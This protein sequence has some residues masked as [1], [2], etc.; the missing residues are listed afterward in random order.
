MS[1]GRLGGRRAHV[2]RSSGFALLSRLIAFYFATFVSLAE[3]Y[4]CFLSAFSIRLPSGPSLSQLPEVSESLTFSL[5]SFSEP[6]RLAISLCLLLASNSV[7]TLS[8]LTASAP[9]GLICLTPV[10]LPTNTI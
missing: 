6:H 5:L 7:L 8:S 3:Y 4:F 9:I 10:P 1:K 2:S